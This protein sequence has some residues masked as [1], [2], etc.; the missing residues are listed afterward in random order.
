LSAPGAI[1]AAR[2]GFGV[3]SGTPE[4]NIVTGR[5]ACALPADQ[6]SA[7]LRNAMGGQP[8]QCTSKHCE[9]WH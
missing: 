8:K 3:Q 6:T 9:F 5:G 1:E 2:E 4:R 7:P